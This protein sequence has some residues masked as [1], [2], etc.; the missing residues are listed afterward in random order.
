[1]RMRRLRVI[2]V[3]LIVLVFLA[4]PLFFRETWAFGISKYQK[5]ISPYKGY[6]CAY[7]CLH[8]DLSCSAYGKEV[9]EKNGVVKGL[10]LLNQRFGDCSL[11]AKQSG[12]MMAL[13][14]KEVD[15]KSPPRL[16]C[17]LCSCCEC[18]TPNKDDAT[19]VGEFCNGNECCCA[20][21]SKSV[22]CDKVADWID[23]K[24]G[25]QGCCESDGGFPIPP[26]HFPPN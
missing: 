24:I 20:D 14:A 16:F 11:A 12:K 22:G 21:L 13:Q 9:I 2:C 15:P 4:T 6:H 7:A 25:C 23:G 26:L 1:M 10:R 8:K 5:Y 19:D 3:C 17:C 18:K